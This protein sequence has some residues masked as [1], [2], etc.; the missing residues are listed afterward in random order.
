MKIKEIKDFYKSS[1]NFL[2]KNEKNKEL[3][4]VPY[5][6]PHLPR[7]VLLQD[8][9]IDLNLFKKILNFFNQIFFSKKNYYS[10]TK[11]NY[12]YLILS[13]LVS[14]DNLRY[15]NDFYFGNLAEKIGSNKVLLVLIDHIGFK[16]NQLKYK[17]K[18]NYIIL[19]KKLNF[20]TEIKLLF[21][22]SIKIF[23]HSFFFK[24]KNLLSIRNILT[25]ID[26]QRISLQVKKILEKYNLKNIFFTFEGNSYEKLVCYETGSLK[27]NIKKIGYQFGV[28]RKFQYSLFSF[29]N[30][31]FD[32]DMI[33]TI[34]KNNKEILLS[35]FKK[36][37][38][39]QNFG[40]FRNSEI[41]TKF[42]KK[43]KDKRKIKVLVMPEGI[44]DEINILLDF[45]KKN[46]DKEIQFTF[47]LHPIFLKNKKFNL[48]IKRIGRN[49]KISK[50]KLDFDIKNNE[51]L[52]YR[53][54]ASVIN[55]VNSGLIPIYL[56][57]KNQFSIDPLFKVNKNHIVNYNNKLLQFIKN[58]HNKKIFIK[59]G[60][61]IK[62]FS[63]NF[64]DK[65]KFSILLKFLKKIK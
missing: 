18:G 10:C 52:L 44:I 57:K 55:V 34:G 23:Y 3:I 49:I 63:E 6:N 46:D 47:R 26:N 11:K 19:S 61:K 43:I 17:I 38:D 7:S 54:T 51:Y 41:N 25:S 36:R 24:K 53:G 64:Y 50:N 5:L 60:M 16:K 56:N 48:L 37:F 28:I 1:N 31:K 12:E 8:Y 22:T 20:L 30:R 27:M 2:K 35:K 4:G 14:Y 45:C 40:L 21:K 32:P 33:F 9:K 58:S 62:K 15:D 39:I 59:E 29:I 13:H 65:P 42:V